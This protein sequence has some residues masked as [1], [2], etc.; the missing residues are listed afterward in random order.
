VGSREGSGGR[1]PSRR[2]KG[3]ALE[4]SGAGRSRGTHESEAACGEEP[5]CTDQADQGRGGTLAGGKRLTSHRT[6]TEGRVELGPPCAGSGTNN[7]QDD[8]AGT[9][10]MRSSTPAGN[11]QRNYG[12]AAGWC[13]R[14]VAME[15]EPTLFF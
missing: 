9:R 12:A 14:G 7:E 2:P 1:G 13:W 6:M 15:G 10:G 5:G 8:D 11:A 3:T 4:T